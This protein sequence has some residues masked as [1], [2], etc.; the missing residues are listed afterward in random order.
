MAWRKSGN[1]GF[2]VSEETLRYP[3]YSSELATSAKYP[4]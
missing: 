2:G 3:G 1:A 4:K